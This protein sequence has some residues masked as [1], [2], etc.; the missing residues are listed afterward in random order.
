M[1]LIRSLIQPLHPMSLAAVL[2]CPL[3]TFADTALPPLTVAGVNAELDQSGVQLR[4]PVDPLLASDLPSLLATLPGVQ[5]RRS[6]GLG[7][8]S[9]ASLRGSNGRQ[10]RILLDGQPLDGGGGEATSLALISPLMLHDVTVHKGRVPVDL[11]GGLA[12]SIHLRTPEVLRAPLLGSVSLGSFGERQ[13][14]AAAQLATDVQ[15]AAG[16]QQADNDFKY[17]N[18]FKPFDPT[19][20]D[21]RRRERRLNADTAQRY[22]LLSLRAPLRV[23]AH[24]IDDAQS[25]PTRLNLP[26]QTAQLDTRAYGL[27]IAGDTSARWHHRLSTRWLDERFRD[28]DSQIGLG[29]QDSRSRTFGIDG[30]SRFNFANGSLA[31]LD[32]GHTRYRAE[33]RIGDVPTQDAERLQLGGAAEAFGDLGAWRANASLGVQWSEDRADGQ[34][35]DHWQWAPAVGLTRRLGPCIAAGNLGSRERLATFFERYGDRGLFRGNPALR[36]ERAHY[37]DLGA[38]CAPAG[39]AWSVD[40]AVFGQDLRDAISPTFNAQG[41][42]RS[43]NTERAEI[44]GVE[45]GGTARLGRWQGQIGGT[46]QSTENRSGPGAARGKQLPG[47]YTEQ[48]NARL[49]TEFWA[50]RWQYAFSFEHGQFYDS[51]NL[52]KAAPLRRHDIGVRGQWQRVGWSVQALNLRDDNPEQFNGFPTPGRHLRLTLSYPAIMSPDSPKE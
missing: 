46:L 31:V 36:P 49:E 2:C 40:A 26:D 27:S 39:G 20:P 52:L 17:R 8:Y 14:H 3:T 34:Q 7:A 44:Y 35:E 10:V 30:Q 37:A 12:G 11:A 5:V 50:L 25:L 1:R 28:R 32:A 21:R 41:V 38:R 19:D 29:A 33:D 43:I 6:G 15:L 45:W 9:E 51:P 47:R 22:A 42:G 23:Q 24:V 13:A 4:V 16:L 48:I 18:A